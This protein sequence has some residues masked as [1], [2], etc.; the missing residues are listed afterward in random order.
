MRIKLASRHKGLVFRTGII[1][2]VT[3]ISKPP[4]VAAQ[5]FR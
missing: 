4:V 5:E 1:P 2:A 3:N